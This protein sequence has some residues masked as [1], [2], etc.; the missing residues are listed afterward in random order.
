MKSNLTDNP[1][2]MYLD[3]AA[4]TPT[5]PE[6]IE[7]MERVMRTAWGNPSSV[8]AAGRRA[9]EV[10]EE[11]RAA[12]ADVLGVDAREVYFTSG[13]TESNNLA[14]RGVCSAR[15][16]A[17]GQIVTSTLEHA[18]VTRSVR[19]MRR[20]GG[21][22][23]SYIDAVAG[24]LDLD[25]LR[26]VLE[27]APTTLITVMNVQ[28]EV[29]YVFPSGEIGRIRDEL[30]PDAVFHVD[31][32]QAFGKLPV[33]PREWHAD[34]LSAASHKIG[35]PRGIGA[36]YVRDGVKMHTNAFGGGQERGLR[37]G[38]EPVFLAAGFA[39]AAVLASREREATFSH[40]KALNVRA[41]ERLSAQVPG[42]I[43]NSPDDAS[44]F[45]LSVSVPGVRNAKSVNYLSDRGVYVSRASACESNHEHIAAGTWRPKHP[46]SLQAAGIP[47]KQGNTTLRASFCAT[48]TEADIDRFV[49]VLAAC[50]REMRAESGE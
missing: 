13:A 39:C 28:N 40:V 5:R 47:L 2:E 17:P 35:G 27:S 37:S 3:N 49:D 32:T 19:G 1:T 26:G 21:W 38:T 41:R 44:P 15:R 20:E 24:K 14:V 50:V 31:A 18:S 45:I 30:A 11:S 42:I 33:A 22:K 4:T 48:T 23:V 6:A 8:H 10:L 7:V 12:I 9:K 34:L 36:L 29:G 46:L 25:Q 16:D 43:V